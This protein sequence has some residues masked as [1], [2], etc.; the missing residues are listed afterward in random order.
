[1][2]GMQEVLRILGELAEGE[3]L[4]I[5]QPQSRSPYHQ[6]W[7]ELPSLS[8]AEHDEDEAHKQ[9]DTVSES[10]DMVCPWYQSQTQ[11][12]RLV[13]TNLATTFQN[14]EVSDCCKLLASCNIVN[15]SAGYM[16]I[17]KILVTHF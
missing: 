5:I 7:A 17:T 10:D 15:V 6:S 2:K 13:D 8:D 14:F 12:Q 11:A 1:M 9:T 4:Q 16:Y 3:E